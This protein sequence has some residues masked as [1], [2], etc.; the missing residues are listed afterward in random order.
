VEYG[1]EGAKGLAREVRERPDE[2]VVF[3]LLLHGVEDSHPRRPGDKGGI[4]QEGP[5]GAID[6]EM[7]KQSLPFGDGTR[8]VKTQEGV[9]EVVRMRVSMTHAC[10]SRHDQ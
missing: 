9:W 6:N 8:G 2:R 1:Q 5:E 3:G 4:F 7:T 10:C